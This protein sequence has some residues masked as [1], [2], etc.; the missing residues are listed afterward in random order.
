MRFSPFIFREDISDHKNTNFAAILSDPGSMNTETNPVTIRSLSGGEPVPNKL[1]S[2][3]NE[4]PESVE[5]RLVRGVRPVLEIETGNA[6]YFQHHDPQPIEEN[7]IESRLMI[8]LKMILKTH[9]SGKPNSYR[10]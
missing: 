2:W 3:D 1:Y 7:G 9:T 4:P 10:P 5:E 8:H 6:G